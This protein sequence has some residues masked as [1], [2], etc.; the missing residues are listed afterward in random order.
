MWVDHIEGWSERSCCHW[1]S[2]NPWPFTFKSLGNLFKFCF[3]GC[4]FVLI[5]SDSLRMKFPNFVICGTPM[6]AVSS[7]SVCS[8]FPRVCCVFSQCLQ[9]FSQG[10]QYFFPFQYTH[11][12]HFPASKDMPEAPLMFLQNTLI[13]A[14][15]STLHTLM[16]L[17]LSFKAPMLIHTYE[18]L[19][20]KVFYSLIQVHNLW[21]L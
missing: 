10:L 9:Y 12:K 19:E 1:T 11:K 18:F 7:H 20:V 21:Q 8:V 14:A 6:S 4:S 15:Y 13:S 5:E 3:P 17:C 16:C 2:Q